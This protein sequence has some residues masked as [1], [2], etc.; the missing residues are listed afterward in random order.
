MTDAERRRGAV[1]TS[2][3]RGR[4]R[5]GDRGRYRAPEVVAGLAG[6]VHPHPGCGGSAA[7]RAVPCRSSSAWS[8]SALYF[9]LSELAFLSAGN[10]A[11]LMTQAAFI[12]TF[13]MAQMFVLLLGEIDLSAGFNAAIGATSRSGCSP[14]NS[15]VARHHRGMA[16]TAAYGALRA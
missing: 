8:S 10:I 9:Q 5:R 4:P 12:I 14:H 3:S 16:A 11:N 6:R 13:G 7:V 15:L 1:T 2:G